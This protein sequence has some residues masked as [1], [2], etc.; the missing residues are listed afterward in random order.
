L[1]KITKKNNQRIISMEI[2]RK[3]WGKINNNT[4]TRL[5][6]NICNRK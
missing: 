6:T 4:N 3:N 1:R 5:Q 2:K